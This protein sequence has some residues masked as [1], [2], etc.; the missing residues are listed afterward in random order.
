MAWQARGLLLHLPDK[1]AKWV[2]EALGYL[3]QCVLLH[4]HNKS[5]D[6]QLVWNLF[7]PV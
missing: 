3:T 6:G 1:L 7:Q 4:R 5:P 2:A